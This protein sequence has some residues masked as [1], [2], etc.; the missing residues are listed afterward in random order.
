MKDSEVMVHLIL[1]TKPSLSTIYVAAERCTNVNRMSQTH[2]T[3]DKTK[4]TVQP[5]TEDT[6]NTDRKG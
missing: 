5:H 3:E 6:R 1:L 4:Q 2:G